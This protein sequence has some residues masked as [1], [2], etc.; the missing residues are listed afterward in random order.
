MNE[1]REATREDARRILR[2]G[3]LNMNIARLI[4]MSQFGLMGSIILSNK[5][6][7]ISN[8]FNR[9]N[10]D[11]ES[12][13]IT[14]SFEESQVNYGTFSFSVGAIVE[15]SGC[16]DKENPEEYLNINI[17]L[18]GDMEVAIKVLY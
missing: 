10:Y 17:K 18:E 5:V 7:F 13:T 14:F 15:I 2:N 3:I 12:N 1:K 4:Q 16:E 11:E 9:I 8:A 6:S